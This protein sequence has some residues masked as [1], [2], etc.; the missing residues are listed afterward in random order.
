MKVGNNFKVVVIDHVK[1]GGSWIFTLIHFL[2]YVLG[3]LPSQEE[4]DICMRVKALPSVSE[5]WV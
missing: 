1:T 2:T 4:V 3:P 5:S